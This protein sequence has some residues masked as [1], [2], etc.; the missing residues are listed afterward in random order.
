MTDPLI[1]EARNAGQAYID[2]FGGDWKALCADLQ[3]RAR[4]EGRTVVSLPPGPPVSRDPAARTPAKKVA[5]VD[6]PPTPT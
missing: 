4:E 6:S 5:E 1:E 2:S 3:R